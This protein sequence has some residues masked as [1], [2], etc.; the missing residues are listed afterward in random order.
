MRNIPPHELEELV[1]D[2]RAIL[3]SKG[4]N[5]VIDS[6]MERHIQTLCAEPVGTLTAN[7]AHASMKVLTELRGELKSLITT[8]T[9]HQK[10][11]N[12]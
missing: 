6:M 5:Y 2:A 1:A 4:F 3:N 12:R 10:I 7:H 8:E 11:R 9:I